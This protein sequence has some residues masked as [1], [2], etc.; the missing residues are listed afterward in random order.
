[1]EDETMTT[2]GYVP[3]YDLSESQEAAVE[4]KAETPQYATKADITEAIQSL[5]ETLK[6][7]IPQPTQ[8]VQQTDPAESYQALADQ[9]Y[10]NPAAAFAK[11]AE[12]A[13]AK[14]E[15]AT[16]AKLAGPLGQMYQD[17]N[18][19]SITGGVTGPEAEYLQNLAAQGKISAETMQDP[20]IKDVLMRAAKQYAQEKTGVK[21]P[22]AEGMVGGGGRF[23]SNEDRTNKEAFERAFPGLDYFKTLKGAN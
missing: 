14:A 18:T 17:F 12:M 11:V 21:A 13:A 9:F 4:P 6:G 23:I 20:V 19:R 1:M 2:D 3:E 10:D 5:A 16:I 22:S 15:E 7:A 8:H